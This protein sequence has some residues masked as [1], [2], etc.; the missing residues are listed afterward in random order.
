ML[1]SAD[2]SQIELR[3]AAHMADV[4]ALKAAFANGD[5]I[6][7]LTAMELFGEVNRDTRGRAK[8]INFSILYGISRW[9]LGQRLGISADEAQAMI[10]RYFE[11]F[12][13][14]NR[15]IAETLDSARDAGFTTTLFGRKTHFSRITSSNQT[16]R[17]GSER[18]AINAP[19]QGTSADIIK[20]AMI[21]MPAALA[22]AGVSGTRM[23]LQVHDEL[24]FE[25]PDGEVAAATAVIREVMAT[26]AEPAVT[27]S[28]PL[29][30]EIGTG[31]NWGAAH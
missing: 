22:A 31:P 7:S 26:A 23:L 13:G 3:L 12:P 6:H 19:I 16:E 8:T 29:G 2:Y 10:D 27:L 18:A 1:L 14:I 20:R 5:D 30:V 4:P 15:Y 28:V 25:V 24:V 21:R 17:Q 9:G 11:R